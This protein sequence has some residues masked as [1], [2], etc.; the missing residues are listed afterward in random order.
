MN[1]IKIIRNHGESYNIYKDNFGNEKAGVIFVHIDSY[2]DLNMPAEIE[3][4]AGIY[5]DSSFIVPLLQKG[6][7]AEM[8]WII[9]A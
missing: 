6:I 8:Y 7:I 3:K 2:S 5:S 1:S 9:P 4:R